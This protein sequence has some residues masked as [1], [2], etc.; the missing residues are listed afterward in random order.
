MKK[1]TRIT[2][3]DTEYKIRMT[4]GVLIDIEEE[5]GIPLTQIG[6]NISIKD[7]TIFLKKA[8]RKLDNTRISDKE[9]KELMYEVDVKEVFGSLGDALKDINPDPSGCDEETKNPNQ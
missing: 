3:N 4:V 7:A 9:W 2:L 1:H 8:V 6:N 5:L